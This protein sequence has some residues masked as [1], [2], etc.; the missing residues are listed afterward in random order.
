ML[1]SCRNGKFPGQCTYAQARNLCDAGQEHAS[2]LLKRLGAVPESYGD[3]VE[4]HM[5]SMGGHFEG[6]GLG[7]SDL[8]Q[9]ATQ[10]SFASMVRQASEKVSEVYYGE[11]RRVAI[12]CRIPVVD[13]V[14]NASEICASVTENGFLKLGKDNAPLA[15]HHRSLPVTIAGALG[16]CPHNPLIMYARSKLVVNKATGSIYCDSFPSLAAWEGFRDEAPPVSPIKCSCLVLQFP[17]FKLL[18][19]ALSW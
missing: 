14:K 16:L 5:L 4:A 19:D 13:A 18:L 7:A 12:A 1:L 3:S 17:C 10:F 15:P 8:A 2:C 6:A 11:S 9:G